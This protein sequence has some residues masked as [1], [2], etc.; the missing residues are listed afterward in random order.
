MTIKNRTTNA[1]LKAAVWLRKILSQRLKREPSVEFAYLFGSILTRR[2]ARDVDVAVFLRG[3]GDP[4]LSAEDVGRHLEGVLR[5]RRKVDVRV[6]N[7]AAAAFAFRVLE[8]GMLLWERDRS[9]R[10]SW[11]AHALSRYQDLRPMRD[12]HD[13]RFLSR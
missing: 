12:L 2:D 13:R 6:L 8:E 1:P 11:E 4:W 3:R 7:D 9:A 5:P 10:L